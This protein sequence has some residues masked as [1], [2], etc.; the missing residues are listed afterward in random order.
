MGNLR[1]MLLGIRA[2]ADS[3]DHF[4]IHDDRESARISMKP[5][6]SRGCDATM[7]IASRDP[8]SLLEQPPFEPCP[9]QAR[10]GE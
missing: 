6:R 4:T 1:V 7:L 8:G 9:A 2:Y 5:R 3:P 10:P